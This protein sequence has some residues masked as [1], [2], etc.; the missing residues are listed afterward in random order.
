MIL[1]VHA[2]ECGGMTAESPVIGDNRTR[3]LDGTSNVKNGP[4]TV[5]VITETRSMPFSIANLNAASSVRRFE[6]A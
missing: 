5:L 2:R 6:S 1:Y 3:I 4:A